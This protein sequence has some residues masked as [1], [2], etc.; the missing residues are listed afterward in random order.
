MLH[1]SWNG[2]VDRP[3]TSFSRMR[4]HDREDVVIGT[5]SSFRCMT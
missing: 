3:T 5:V 2:H 1:G 4:I